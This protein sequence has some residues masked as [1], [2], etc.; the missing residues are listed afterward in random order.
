M[1]Y[2]VYLSGPIRGLVYGEATDWR[3]HVAKKLPQHILAICPMRYK[4]FLRNGQVLDLADMPDHPIV[5]RAGLVTRDRFD[6]M[7][8]DAMLVNL[9][10]AKDISIGTCVEFGWADAY[11]KP[12]ITAIGE[13]DV[14]DHG[15]IHQLSGFVVRTLD[16]A[17]EVAQAILSPARHILS[18]M[19]HA[20]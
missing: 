18:N 9:I 1:E 5:R 12:I 13:N 3:D 20:S 17:I 14:H 8:C 10:G 19:P 11:R 16:E 6:V 4:E 15:F 2:S 7:R